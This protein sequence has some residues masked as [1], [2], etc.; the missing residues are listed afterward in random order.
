MLREN[1]INTIF[2]KDILQVLRSLDRTD[3][4]MSSIDLIT[5]SALIMPE[6]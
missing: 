2:N 3:V 1:Y 4:W 6:K 5:M